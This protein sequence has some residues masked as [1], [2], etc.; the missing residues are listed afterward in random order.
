M[1]EAKTNFLCFS[2]LN[3]IVI[4]TSWYSWTSWISLCIHLT[5]TKRAFP[6]PQSCPALN[7]TLMHSVLIPPW[8]HQSM[9]S[10]PLNSPVHSCSI[11]WGLS[12]I[13]IPTVS[14]WTLH[15]SELLEVHDF[16]TVPA[17]L[18]GMDN[19]TCK[20][21]VFFWKDYSVVTY[22]NISNRNNMR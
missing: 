21:L 17:N 10:I 20:N 22:Y 1:G 19:S 8:A 16:P 6:H 3:L 7:Q 2:P 9:K 11:R 5:I 14:Q 12:R 15:S 13:S 18:I 4:G